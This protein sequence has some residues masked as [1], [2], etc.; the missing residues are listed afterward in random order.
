MN[1]TLN[2][3]QRIATALLVLGLS[4][5]A[6]LAAIQEFGRLSADGAGYTKL[7]QDY[8]SVP[9]RARKNAQGSGADQSAALDALKAKR[10]AQS[11]PR[12]LQ[13]AR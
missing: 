5:C 13:R 10:D 6:N 3:I 1:Q 7:T 11:S 12:R 2:L 9:D 4:G 8:L